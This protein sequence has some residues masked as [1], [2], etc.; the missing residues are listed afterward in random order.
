MLSSIF[1]LHPICMI[2]F[3]F[4]WMV[5]GGFFFFLP[6]GSG[7]AIPLSAMLPLPGHLCPLPQCHNSYSSF[8]SQLRQNFLSEVLSDSLSSPD[9]VSFLY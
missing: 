4:N 1:H 7:H 6:W 8:R 9:K 5:V 2:D 3:L